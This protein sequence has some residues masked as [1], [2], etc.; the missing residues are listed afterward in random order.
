MNT[1]QHVDD[2][3]DAKTFRICA[4]E[5]IA[6][7][8]T[9]IALDRVEAITNEEIGVVVIVFTRLQRCLLLCLW[10]IGIL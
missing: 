7:R 8:H 9:K 4:I 6:A 3:V 2:V 10:L 1:D 5:F